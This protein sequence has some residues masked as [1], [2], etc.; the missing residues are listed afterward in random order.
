[1]LGKGA[2]DFEASFCSRGYLLHFR[3]QSVAWAAK[4]KGKMLFQTAAASLR[5]KYGWSK[6]VAD[7]VEGL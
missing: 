4:W 3:Q 5:L 2:Y 6:G 1:M 7:V